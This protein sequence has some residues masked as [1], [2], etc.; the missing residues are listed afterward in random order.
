MRKSGYDE[1]IGLCLLIVMVQY[2]QKIQA[3]EK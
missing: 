2:R 3:N 1:M